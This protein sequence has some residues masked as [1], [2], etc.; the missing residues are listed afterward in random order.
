MPGGVVVKLKKIAIIPARSGSKGLKDKNILNL[1]DKPL[2][3]YTIE[4]ALKSN[5]FDKVIVSTDDIYYK[6]I[7]EKYGAQVILRDKK[8]AE[9]NTPTYFVIEDVLNKLNIEY[10]YFVLLQPT[11][12][13]RTEIH[14]LES[15]SKF[16]NNYVNINF[17]V[18]MVESKKSSSLIKTLD[19]QNRLSKFDQDFSNYTRQ[20]NREY[21]P[22][23]AIFI[24][25]PKYYIQKRH[26]F[27]EDSLAYIMSE[28][29]SVD[30]DTIIDFELATIIETKRRNKKINS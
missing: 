23:G 18:S 16:E 9:D 13:F 5:I 10:D 26:F 15:T 24:A 11:S 28:E 4:A 12:P 29:D 25:K 27:G 3:A 22:N 1:L 30:I 21:T 6:K 19:N 14:I 7:A 8:L 2:M 20:K 17:L